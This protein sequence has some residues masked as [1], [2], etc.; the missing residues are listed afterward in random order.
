MRKSTEAAMALEDAEIVAR[1]S[2]FAV[3]RPLP[4]TVATFVSEL[5]QFTVKPLVVVWPFDNV[6]VAVSWKVSPVLIDA[7]GAL[8]VSAVTAAEGVVGATGLSPHA[9]S[10][11]HPP[12]K[13]SSAPRR[14]I[15]CMRRR[16]HRSPRDHE[17][18]PA[19]G[20]RRQ[21][22]RRPVPTN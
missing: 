21:G 17:T 5:D 14:G 20:R 12:Y 13:T 9:A 2:D 15:E 22:Q 1:P 3:T 4:F 10:H 8:I 11:A 18:G 16:L 19:G 6:A 7:G